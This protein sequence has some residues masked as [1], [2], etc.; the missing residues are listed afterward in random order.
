MLLPVHIYDILHFLSTYLCFSHNA[1]LFLAQI[2]SRT[3]SIMKKYRSKKPKL[4]NLKVENL[5]I[6][7]LSHEGRGI[8]SLNGKTVFVQGALAG[9][10][11]DY[12]LVNRKKN[13]E[14]G[15]CVQ[16]HSSS[17]QRAHPVCAH[18]EQ[19]G[20]CALQH[21]NITAQLQFKEEV[22]LDLILR[23][24]HCAPKTILKTITGSTKHYRHKARLSVR[25]L[26]KDER[27][28]IGFR[29]KNN[30]RFIADIE[31][32]PILH[33]SFDEQLSN[34]KQLLSQFEQK[35]C[36]SQIEWAV[37]DDDTALIFRNLTDLYS[38]ESLLL[39]EFAKTSGLKIFLQ[40]QGY[41]SIVPL[42]P[43]IKEPF[44]RYRLTHFNLEFI[45]HPSDF[46][47]VNPE[48]NNKMVLQAM[49]LLDLK[50]Q[51]CALDL[52]CGLGNFALPMALQ[53]GSVTGIESSALMVK[54]AQMIAQHNQIKNVHYLQ[55]DLYT[56]GAQLHTALKRATKIVL[57]PP[58]SGAQEVVKQLKNAQATH[59]LYVSCNPVT[60][61]RDAN[62]LVNDCGYRL[63]CAGVMDMFPHTAHVE[64]MALFRKD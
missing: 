19:C 27:H 28:L 25:Y 12:T 35:N 55:R 15:L 26:A 16:I 60:L 41:D 9:E 3:K 51:D 63:D 48:I 17:P 10:R 62:I 8:G 1:P 34:L 20:G 18:Y 57:D 43:S 37:G 42:I 44:L 30:S 46:I 31:A 6:T 21:M 52:F 59:V 64:S 53:C 24:A 50:V 40:P 13:Y 2:E 45:F 49:D 39:Q 61:A 32:C 54:R 29:E 33:K 23:T 7:R 14:E 38:S 36:I 56:D 58:R 11:V 5:H 47:Q 22:L 4:P